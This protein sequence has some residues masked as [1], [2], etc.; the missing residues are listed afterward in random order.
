MATVVDAPPPP[1]IHL[2]L[3][4]RPQQ[5]ASGVV[6]VGGD[7]RKLQPSNLFAVRNTIHTVARILRTYHPAIHIQGCGVQVRA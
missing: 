5:C 4:W 7:R 1:Q 3:I 2:R 6:L